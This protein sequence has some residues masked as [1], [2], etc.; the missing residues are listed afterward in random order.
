[1]P[2]LMIPQIPMPYMPIMIPPISGSSDAFISRSNFGSN[3]D[4]STSY[5]AANPYSGY[6][7][8]SSSTQ[9]NPQVNFI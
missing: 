9:T 1:M 8:I 5:V 2:Q 7:Y 6:K 3:G 4:T